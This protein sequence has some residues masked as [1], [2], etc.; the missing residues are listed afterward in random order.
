M[1]TLLLFA[2]GCV[3]LVITAMG[4]WVL[5]EVLRQEGRW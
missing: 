3:V 4:V 1:N 5:R 2:L